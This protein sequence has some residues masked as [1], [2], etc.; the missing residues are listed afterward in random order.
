[1]PRGTMADEP[2]D[3]DKN[4]RELDE[5]PPGGIGGPADRDEQ[6]DPRRVATQQD[7]GR[8]LTRSRQRAGLSVREVAKA[9]GIPTSTA[10]DYFSGRHLPPPT[11]PEA[12]P[13]IL[14]ACGVTDPGHVREWVSAL[15]R[16]RRAPGRRPAGAAAP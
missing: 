3:L 11:Q 2:N 9:A 16:A 7:F 6:P 8:E 10:G 13:R 1:M 12:L 15:A 5:D 14:A 4:P